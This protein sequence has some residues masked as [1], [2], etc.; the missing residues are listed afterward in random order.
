MQCNFVLLLAKT[1]ELWRKQF[2]VCS[3][4]IICLHCYH[5]RSKCSPLAVT[6]TVRCWSHRWTARAWC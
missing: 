2:S 1:R 6:H 4:H 5:E 3:K